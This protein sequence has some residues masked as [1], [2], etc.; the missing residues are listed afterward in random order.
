M[1]GLSFPPRRSLRCARFLNHLN[2]LNM[3]QGWDMSL[4]A[5]HLPTAQVF[6]DD[7]C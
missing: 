4:A 6:A 3:S 7:R 5:A 2:E 1:R